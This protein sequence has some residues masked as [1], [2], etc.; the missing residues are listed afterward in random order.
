MQRP[1]IDRQLE[2][3]LVF[4]SIPGFGEHPLV[5]SASTN[6][7]LIG[8]AFDYLLRFGLQ[9]RVSFAMSREW[10]AEEGLRSLVARGYGH[11]ARRLSQKTIDAATK[12]IS[13]A[14]A[15]C[16]EYCEH[17]EITNALLQSALRLAQID[18]LVRSGIKVKWFGVVDLKDMR[19]LRRLMDLVPWQEFTPRKRCLL[20]PTFGRASTLVG[21]A[22]ADLLLDDTLIEIKTTKSGAFSKTYVKQLVGYYVLFLIGGIDGAEAEDDIAKI[23]VYAARYGRLVRIPVRSVVPPMALRSLTKLFQQGY[24]G[25]HH[26]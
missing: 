20:N 4:P 8:T 9:R 17:G 10:V 2:A 14:K 18:A 6:Y 24:P 11:P 23:G 26:G 21:G 16:S 22:D 15:A 12:A 25:E 5:P 19:E 3:L 7:S 1:E 13:E